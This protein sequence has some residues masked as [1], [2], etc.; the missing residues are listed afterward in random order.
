M[1]R[2]PGA[3][4]HSLP[5]AA[6]GQLDPALTRGGVVVGQEGR[7]PLVVR[8]FRSRPTRIG[9]FAA[10]YVARVLAHRALAV[11]GRVV[12]STERSAAWSSLVRAAPAG[13]AWVSV[14]P[15]GAPAPPAGTMLRPVLLV[16]DARPDEDPRRELGPWQTGVVVRP[17][18]TPRNV[19]W[20]H[21]YQ[22][23]VLQRMAPEA[24]GPVRAAFSL[25]AE[26]AQ[27]LPRMPDDTIALAERGRLRFANLAVTDVERSAFGSPTRQE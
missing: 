26:A 10:G 22:L 24:V 19:A 9:V 2:Q 15:P 1:I 11:G 3:V 25:P 7:A 20:L 12:I 4:S 21:S 5:E 23:I 6:T 14:V 13:P 17:F 27:W 8:L 18:L 16:D